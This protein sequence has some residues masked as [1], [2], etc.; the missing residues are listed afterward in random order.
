MRNG[1]L[2]V[3]PVEE[4]KESTKSPKLTRL[5]AEIDDLKPDEKAEVMKHLLG[6]DK[7]LQVVFGNSN[8]TATTMFQ[9]NI[10][11]DADVSNLLKAVADRMEKES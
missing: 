4:H 10:T 9:I 11:S 6:S 1:L 3:N 8:V 2:T 7:S 5:K